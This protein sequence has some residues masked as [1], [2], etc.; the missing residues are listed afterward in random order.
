VIAWQDSI[1]ELPVSEY[2]DIQ[3]SWGYKISIMIQ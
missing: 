1:I 3:H 2:L